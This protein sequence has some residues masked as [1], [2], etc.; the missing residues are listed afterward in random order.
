MRQLRRY[1]VF[2]FFYYAALGAFSPYIGR[3]V[4][5][6]GH[7]GYVLGLMLALWYGSRVF[8]PPAWT[9]LVHRSARPG[10]LLLAGCVATTLLCAGFTV[11][12]TAIGLCVVM[13]LF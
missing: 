7:S 2:Y 6:L 4:D 3:F 13:A 11:F 10:Q 8:G 9:E 1:S 5:A 12:H